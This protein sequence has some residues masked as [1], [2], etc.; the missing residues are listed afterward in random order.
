M[1]KRVCAYCNASLGDAQDA[2]SSV[3]RISHGLCADCVPRFLAGTGEGVM[4]FLN[5][6]PAPVLVVDQDARI[7]AANNGVQKLVGKNLAETQG[8]FPGEVFGCQY[9][10]LPGGCGGTVHCKTCTIR[11]SVTA[12]F[13]SGMPCVRVPAFMDLGELRDDMRLRFLISTEKVFG[14][15]FLRIDEILPSEAASKPAA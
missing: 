7:I 10:K 9:S 11:R 14:V 8:H 15:V 1:M 12:T 6:L 13:E 4:D 5:S 3:E 2:E